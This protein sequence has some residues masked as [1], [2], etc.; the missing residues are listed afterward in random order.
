MTYVKKDEIDEFP[1]LTAYH[2]PNCLVN[3]ISLDL[4]QS[5]YYNTF[6]S[7]EHNAFSV[8]LDDEHTIIFEAPSNFKL[9]V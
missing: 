2:N 7:E 1:S 5:T 8:H 3:I 6:N 9:M 4:L